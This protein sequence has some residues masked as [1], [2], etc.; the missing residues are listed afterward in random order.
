MYGGCDDAIVC[1]REE[2]SQSTSPVEG[3]SMARV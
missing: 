3:G 2:M 1:V